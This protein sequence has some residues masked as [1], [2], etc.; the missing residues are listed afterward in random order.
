[1]T[2]RVWP[3]I[4][5]NR[6]FTFLQTVLIAGERYGISTNQ[7]MTIYLRMI[8]KIAKKMNWRFWQFQLLQ[9]FDRGL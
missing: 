6:K 9:A 3:T 8:H 5:T 2:L 7:E 4:V 1:M